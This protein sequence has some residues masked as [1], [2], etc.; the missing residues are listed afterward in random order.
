MSRE[1]F[2]FITRPEIVEILKAVEEINPLRYARCGIHQKKKI[3]IYDT[4]GDI[5]DF[6]SNKSGNHQPERYLVVN[7]GTRIVPYKVRLHSGGYDFRVNQKGNTDS[8]MIWPGGY[9][10]AAHLICGHLG[11]IHETEKS[12][13]LLEVLRKAVIGGCKKVPGFRYYVSPQAI[14]TAGHARLIT[15]NI[16]EPIGMDLVMPSNMLE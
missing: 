8:V 11:T 3:P 13:R 1:L 6:G 15:A 10:D 5:D 16:H 2:F 7:A 14:K 12:I 9:Y 4:A